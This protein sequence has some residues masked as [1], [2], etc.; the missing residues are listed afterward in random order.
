M[1]SNSDSSARS[2]SVFFLPFAVIAFIARAHL[3]AGS[4]S[5]GLC[6]SNGELLDTLFKGKEN[7]PTL[8]FARN[9]YGARATAS[10][11]DQSR[12]ERAATRTLTRPYALLVSAIPYLLLSTI[13]F[14]ILIEPICALIST[15]ACFGNLIVQSLIW[16]EH[17]GSVAEAGPRLLE[18]A[19]IVG[20]AF[21]GGYLFTLRTL[22]R[23]VMNFELSPI[24][25]LRA[26]VHILSGSIIALL[27]YRTLGGTPYLSD[28][29]Q[30]TS[31]PDGEPLR[32]WL[33]VAFIAAMCR[34]SGCRRWCATCTSP[35]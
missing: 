19:A 4:A 8:E 15:D 10:A 2:A 14:L 35:T 23:A 30:V 17:P 11:A 27:L 3:F 33:A 25:W 34:I 31:T 22:L 9:K 24:T 1:Y 32:L 21:L 28:V 7:V 16:I 29:L 12:E 13:G 5:W 26:A 20:A 18:A 6:I